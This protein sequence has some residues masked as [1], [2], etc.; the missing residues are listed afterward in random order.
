MNILH[1]RS[2]LLIAGVLVLAASAFFAG[3]NSASADIIASYDFEDGRVPDFGGWDSLAWNTK[4]PA[5][6]LTDPNGN[7]FLRMT[8]S[9][10]DTVPDGTYR[11]ELLV[12]FHD[13]TISGGGTATYNFSVRV[14][15]FNPPSAIMFQLFFWP[16]GWTVAAQVSK[17]EG[18]FGVEARQATPANIVTPFIYDQWSNFSLTVHFDVDPALGWVDVT[19]NGQYL[20][21]ITGRTLPLTGITKVQ[22]FLDVY[23]SVGTMDFDNVE[24]TLGPSGS[25]GPPPSTSSCHILDS[26]QAVPTGFGASYNVLS[27]AQELLLKANCTDTS[28]TYPVGNGSQTQ[29]IY[30]QGYYWTGTAW[31]PFTFSCNNLIS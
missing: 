16:G 4:V 29:Y 27:S 25:Q 6:V 13:Y 30:N 7:H 22:A 31:S 28:V 10:E 3:A 2:T 20:G 23:G 1:N 8:T 19:H 24:I 26:S 21:R 17:G 5:A 12:G 15:S 18:L 14:P 11:S 9:P